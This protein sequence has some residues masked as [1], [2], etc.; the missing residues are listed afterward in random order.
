MATHHNEH[1]LRI[2]SFNVAGFNQCDW[3]YVQHL[4]DSHDFV[5]LQE[6]WLHSSEGHRIT[7]S[8]NNVAMYF[9]SG[10]PDDSVQAG[11]KYGGCCILWR[12]RLHLRVSPVACDNRRL[13]AIKTEVGGYPLM[14]ANIYMPCDTDF[15]VENLNV[16]NEVL[17]DVTSIADNLNV[18]RII[19]GGDFNTDI[20]RQY[21][22]HT[23]A[24]LRFVTEENLSLLNNLPV[25]DIDYTYE[26]AI[27]GTRS[28]LDHFVVSQQLVAPI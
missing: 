22:W 10:M 4:V 18:D 11:R 3:N 20:A 28:T 5:L 23:A 26:S 15:D 13:C 27:H 14:L 21:S 7:D 9:V 8:L 2:C 19:I 24:L 17:N 6:L 25:Y 16:F 12:S 1:P